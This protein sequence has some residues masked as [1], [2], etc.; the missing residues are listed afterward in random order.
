MKTIALTFAFVLLIA[1]GLICFAAWAC[2]SPAV[3]LGDLNRIQV[4]MTKDQV[5]A[6]LGKPDEEYAA[7]NTPGSHWMYKNLWKWYAL[8]ID[9]TEDDKVIRYVHD[10]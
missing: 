4:G 5:Q 3:P 10:D 6:I 1:F 7:H 8:R 9:F 2:N